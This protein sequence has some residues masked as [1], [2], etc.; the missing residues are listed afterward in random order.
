[1]WTSERVFDTEMVWY[2]MIGG[3]GSQGKCEVDLG[4][5]AWRVVGNVKRIWRR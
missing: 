4:G 1:M 2:V 3:K 5:L